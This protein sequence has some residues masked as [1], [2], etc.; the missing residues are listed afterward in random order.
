VP[1]RTEGRRIAWSSSLSS[2][3][4]LLVFAV[5]A[6]AGANLVAFH[7]HLVKSVSA[8]KNMTGLATE[9]RILAF[10]I[11]LATPGDTAG[12]DNALD[13]IVK[14]SP[15][16]VAAWQARTAYQAA[17]GVPMESVLA[18]FRMSALT[19]S[20]E[21][22]YMVRRAM[23]GLQYWSELP[24]EDRLTVVRDLVSGSDFV[25]DT[26]RNVLAAKSKAERDEIR[27]KVIASGRASK[28]LLQVLGE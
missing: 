10:E 26:Y 5:T 13:E 7:A 27:A 8:W 19:G 15:T 14:A 6:Y 23:F 16:S 18:G 2:L 21:G 24:E 4:L 1:E 28:A 17:H 9:A 20:H 11:A 22:Y 25:L 3:G 12:I